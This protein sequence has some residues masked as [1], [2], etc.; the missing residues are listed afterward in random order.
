MGSSIVIRY[1]HLKF[2]NIC[3]LQNML[4]RS[5][6][7]CPSTFFAIKV[8]IVYC[9]IV[10]SF[11]NL[12]QNSQHSINM[13][14]IAFIYFCVEALFLKVLHIIL[15]QLP[16]C[17]PYKAKLHNIRGWIWT[18]FSFLSIVAVALLLSFL[19]IYFIYF[20]LYILVLFYSPVFFYVLGP[21]LFT[22]SIS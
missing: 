1:H 22:L 5:R 8:F 13:H 18:F 12:L 2:S 15:I 4:P 20:S 17:F 16:T 10:S 14:G 6:V 11:S 9:K 21:C 3:K 7:F 19:S